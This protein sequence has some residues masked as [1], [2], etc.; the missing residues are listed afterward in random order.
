M[1]KAVSLVN[2]VTQTR[3]L[4]PNSVPGEIRRLRPNLAWV[5]NSTGWK[6]D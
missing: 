1:R 3:S 5:F 6:S 2:W 4:A